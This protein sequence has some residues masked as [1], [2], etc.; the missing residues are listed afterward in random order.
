MLSRGA[1]GAGCCR[2][3][4]H[5]EGCYDDGYLSVS[6]PVRSQQ[7]AT[8]LKSVHFHQKAGI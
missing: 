2:R 1:V 8:R 6:L 5:M 7:P 4:V 3:I